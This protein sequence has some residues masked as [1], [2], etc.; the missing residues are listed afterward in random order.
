MQSL[1]FN[2]VIRQFFLKH[3][4]GILYIIYYYIIPIIRVWLILK[5]A[6]VPGYLITIIKMI[7]AN[8]QAYVHIESG[9]FESFHIGLGVKQDCILSPL[10]LEHV[11][12]MD[13]E[14]KNGMEESGMSVGGKKISNLK[15]K[16]EMLLKK[17]SV[18]EKSKERGAEAG[19]L[20]AK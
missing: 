3:Y 4:I 18:N 2:L 9:L 12:R 15:L 11:R 14:H 8:N 20:F 17:I 19:L 7:Y 13:Y 10:P 1:P 16:E 6:G 5:E